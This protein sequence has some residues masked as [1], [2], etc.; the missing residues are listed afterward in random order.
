MPEPSDPDAVLMLRVQRGDLAALAELVEQH[1]QGV[2]NFVGRTLGDPVE[3]EDIAQAV[4]V[5]VFKAAAR[6]TVTA[7]F[8]TWLY[9]IA[10]NLCLNE[11][12]RRARHRAVSLNLDPEA[13]G[14]AYRLELA[15]SAPLA[16]H[17]LLNQ[18]LAAKVEEAIAA[19]PE[20]QRT[21]LLLCRE[22]E[23]SYDEIARVLGCSVSATK[24]IIHRGRE[25]IK[26]VLKPYLRDGAWPELRTQLPV[27]SGFSTHD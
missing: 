17:A 15:A 7:R 25:A 27:P 6:Y 4:F 13:D 24:S 20:K 22:E 16:D 10:R 5:Q 12:R 21:A 26:E 3:A 11:L 1:R 9:T 19:L 2:V 18:E 14:G 8:R 23:S